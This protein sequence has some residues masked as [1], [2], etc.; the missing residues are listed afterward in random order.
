MCK[1]IPTIEN[2]TLALQVSCLRV[3]S[4]APENLLVFVTILQEELIAAKVLPANYDFEAHK[5]L[6]L[7]NQAMCL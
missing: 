3:K 5:E 7:C 2:H 6:V 1:V 4:S